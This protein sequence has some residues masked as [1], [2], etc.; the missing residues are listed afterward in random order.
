MKPQCSNCNAFRA[1]GKDSG[2]CLANP[3]QLVTSTIETGAKGPLTST[4]GMW[5]PVG[6]NAWCRAWQSNEGKANG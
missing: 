2:W 3:P 6:G 4:Q 1:S 5:P